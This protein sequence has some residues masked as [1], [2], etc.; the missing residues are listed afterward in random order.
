MSFDGAVFWLMKS[1]PDV[2]GI[3]DL[4][5]QQRGQWEGVRNFQARNHLRRMRVG[6]LAFFYHSSTTPP[7]IAGLLRISR[8]AYPDPTQ[9]D[10]KS[11]YHDPKSKP[12]NPRWSMVDVE[13]VEKFRE[14]ISL[15]QLKADR[16][17][18]G[19]LVI[20]RGMRLSVQPVERAEFEH[21]LALAS[22]K[23]PMPR[24]D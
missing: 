17:L 1:E 14:L 6:E 4:Q 16:A 22:A 20:R 5:R 19:M 15:E 3:D 12:E 18:S 11:P 10:P 24:G 21:V 9:F 7:G 8:E 23:T 2:Y 13:F